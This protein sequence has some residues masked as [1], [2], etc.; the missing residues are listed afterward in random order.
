MRS[1]FRTIAAG[2]NLRC[3]N[4]GRTRRTNGEIIAVSQLRLQVNAELAVAAE[5]CAQYEYAKTYNY[6]VITNEK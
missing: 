4:G 3:A 1:R 5:W 2:N 6:V